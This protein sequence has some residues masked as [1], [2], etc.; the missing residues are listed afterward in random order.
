MATA[1]P[2]SIALLPTPT[3][4]ATALTGY[5]DDRG[6]PAELLMS[7]YN[8]I[9]RHEYLRAYWYWA[10]NL[11]ADQLPAY[12]DFANGYANTASVELTLGAITGD[13]GAG[14]LYYSVPVALVATTTDGATQT[15]AGCYQ[16]HL[17]RPRIQAA[18]PFQPLAIE[19]AD[20]RQVSNGGDP[21]AL[22]AQACPDAAGQPIGT[23]SATAGTGAD[24]AVYLDNRSTPADVL[25][26]LYNAI[27]RQEY[28]RAYSYWEPGAAQLPPFD[29]FQQG[30]A[31]TTSVQFTSG[32]PESDPGAGQLN[33]ALP[34]TLVA[35]QA[36][37]ST[38]TFVGC[39]RLHLS[40]PAIQATPPFQ[41]LA[42]TSGALQQVDNGA[43]TTAL[44][45]TACQ[46]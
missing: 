25:R 16:L 11:P 5:L 7:Y 19:R 46:Q 8:A 29:Q 9:N 37:G 40:Q 13:V 24:S 15:F 44:M 36:D 34:A 45:A 28:A 43:D 12:D 4:D 6:G 20:V 35:Q 31:R 17:A 38:E 10:Q 39:Y 42:I 23:P 18:P 21:S 41:P 2:G 22:A 27:N 33:Y 3:E 26:S 32:A 14:Q 30:Y 1:T